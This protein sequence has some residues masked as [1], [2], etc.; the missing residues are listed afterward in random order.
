MFLTASLVPW[1]LVGAAAAALAC[2]G[3]GCYVGAKWVHADWAKE[4]AAQ[5]EAERRRI[6]LIRDEQEA[7]DMAAHAAAQAFEAERQQLES[8]HARSLTQL[9]KSLHAPVSCPAGG[10]LAD[11]VLPAGTL[12]GLRLAAGADRVHPPEPASSGAGR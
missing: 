2:F 12:R 8:T 7:T 1:R 6:A 4:T 10:T 9:R 5:A 11:V 3:G